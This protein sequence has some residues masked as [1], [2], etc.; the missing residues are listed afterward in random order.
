MEAEERAKP[1]DPNAVKRIRDLTFGMLVKAAGR[2]DSFSEAIV[3]RIPA[4][5]SHLI[6]YWRAYNTGKNVSARKFEASL[7]APRVTRKRIAKVMASRFNL[8]RWTP[9]DLGLES[10]SISHL[11]PTKLKELSKKA[12]AEHAMG[13]ATYFVLA[14]HPKRAKRFAQISLSDKRRIH[15]DL[16]NEWDAC[17]KALRSNFHSVNG[18]RAVN[19]L[20]TLSEHGLKLS[21]LK[22]ERSK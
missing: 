18:W 5:Y 10:H 8:A 14:G 3:A 17:V 16:L 22:E 13:W 21:S 11:S 15:R 1:L 9:R 7:Y 19:G 12:G 20:K 2:N 6:D 4:E